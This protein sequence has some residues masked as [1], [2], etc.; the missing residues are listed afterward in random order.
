MR[1]WR[2]LSPHSGGWRVR[3]YAAQPA[4]SL[5]KD[6]GLSA[7]ITPRDADRRNRFQHTRI[8]DRLRDGGGIVFQ[9]TQQKARTGTAPWR[10]ARAAGTCRLRRSRRGLGCLSDSLVA[11]AAATIAVLSSTPTTP[12]TDIASRTRA[13][14]RLR[15]SGCSNRSE[16]TGGIGGLERARLLGGDGQLH[17]HLPRS[18]TNAAVRY[19]VVGSN[20][21][22]RVISSSLEVGFAPEV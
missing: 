14:H 9:A 4:L 5:T 2:A 17:P 22:R 10:A 16:K 13:R 15:R 21:S 3:K 12:L 1:Y 11:I 7:R 19:V 8:A 6:C 18:L 20:S